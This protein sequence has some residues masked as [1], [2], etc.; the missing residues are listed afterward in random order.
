MK[1]AESMYMNSMY[2]NRFLSVHFAG[3]QETVPLLPLRQVYDLL[4]SSFLK[5]CSHFGDKNCLL[6]VALYE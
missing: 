3:K 2:F 4:S 6:F 1:E 5:K